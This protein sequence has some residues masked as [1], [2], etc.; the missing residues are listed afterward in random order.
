MFTMLIHRWGARLLATEFHAA[1]M[2]SCAGILRVPRNT[3]AFTVCLYQRIRLWLIRA[4]TATETSDS[5]HRVDAGLQWLHYSQLQA[6]AKLHISHC[7]LSVWRISFSWLA[8]N[9][10]CFEAQRWLCGFCK[11]YLLQ[12]PRSEPCSKNLVAPNSCSTRWNT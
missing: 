3:M 8:T 4:S 12:S 10:K 7:H 9:S 5:V 11:S 2:S 1:E 6:P